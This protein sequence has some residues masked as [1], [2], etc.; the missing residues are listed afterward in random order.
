MRL[1]F[2]LVGAL[3]AGMLV[4]A[5]STA[6]AQAPPE[7]DATVSRL[8][9]AT[10]FL[11]TRPSRL[12][13]LSA[14]RECGV[15][16]EMVVLPPGT[17]TMGSPRNEAGRSEDEGPR[18]VVR[19]A[20]F[21]IGRAEVTF[22]L[23]DACAADG[24]CRAIAEGDGGDQGWGRAQ[25]P[26]ITVSWADVTGEGVA[27]AGFLAWLNSRDG[28]V[29]APYRLPSEAEWAYAARAGTST[30]FSFGDDEA[31][32]AA[33]GW[34][35]MNSAGRTQPVARL[36]PNAFGLFDVHGGVFEWTQDCWRETLE[37]RP[38]DGAA[39]TAAGCRVAVVRGGAW[40][41]APRS[42]RSA[43]RGWSFRGDGDVS[44]GFRV[45]R[46]L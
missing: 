36:A 1:G 39:V 10:V 15:C 14:F 19:V 23:W 40:S 28:V 42:L 34:F 2:C 5:A 25:R 29:G 17:F 38:R 37:G 46:G 3:V 43:E 32:L 13:P 11:A 18:V 6:G 31:R 27:E 41:N 30:R 35:A 12:A 7:A 22:A 26:V 45:A 8:D 9:G 20:P 16:P 24:Y 4:G 33:H 44:I 21:A